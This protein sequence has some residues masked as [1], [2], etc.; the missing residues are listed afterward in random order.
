[1]ANFLILSKGEFSTWLQQQSVSRN[2]KLV[3]NHH[4]YI[5]AYKHF[6]GA[7]HLALMQAM[8][9][10]HLERGFTE[11]AQHFTT[12]P[13]G[14]I[15]VGRSLNKVPAGI[16]GAN[17]NGI[18]IE[19]VGNFDTGGDTLN[20]KHRDTIIA[21]NAAL[22]DRFGLIPST[23]SIVYHHWYDLNTGLRTNGSG[24]T[25]TCPGTNFF[26]GN[27]VADAEADFIPLIAN[28]VNGTPVP[29]TSVIAEGVVTARRLNVRAGSGQQTA[30][31]EVITEGTPVRIF[32]KKDGWLLIDEAGGKWVKDQ[33]VELHMHLTFN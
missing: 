2:I 24:T 12:F 16:K 14:Q 7:N 15:G 30:I 10:A 27:K 33:Y 23:D 20:D 19:H 17:S 21:I 4:T 25:K 32:G 28:A 1:M 18:C 11:I 22:C 26:G 31:V 5:P 9:R 8:Q 6:S 29:L 13:D 3:Q